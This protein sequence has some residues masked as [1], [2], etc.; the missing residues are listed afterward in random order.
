VSES[1]GDLAVSPEVPEDHR[2]TRYE[3]LVSDVHENRVVGLD[4]LAV[5]TNH[6]DG[7]P[8]HSQRA[9]AHSGARHIGALGIAHTSLPSTER[10]TGQSVRHHSCADHTE[11][12]A[13]NNAPRQVRNAHRTAPMAYLQAGGCGSL[14]TRCSTCAT[15]GE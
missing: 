13:Q 8:A 7:Q 10:T 11:R 3:P 2:V 6:I 15:I 12:G 4:D 14:S 1:N 9:A 5:G